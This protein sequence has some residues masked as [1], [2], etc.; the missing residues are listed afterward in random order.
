MIAGVGKS[1]TVQRG[2]ASP[3]SSRHQQQQ[4]SSGGGVD[5]TSFLKGKFAFVGLV[6]ADLLVCSTV[7]SPNRLKRHFGAF[8]RVKLES[9]S[10]CFLNE[11]EM[12][13]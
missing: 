9:Q 5:R 3:A 11:A 10:V 13:V 1:L 7:L 2:K 6:C 12:N 4:S 8:T